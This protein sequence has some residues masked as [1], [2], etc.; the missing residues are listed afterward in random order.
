MW[1]E[2]WKTGWAAWEE[3]EG[4]QAKLDTTCSLECN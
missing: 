4:Q 1:L 2:G 3:S